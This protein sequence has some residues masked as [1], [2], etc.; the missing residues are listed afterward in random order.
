MKTGLIHKPGGTFLDGWGHRITFDE[1]RVYMKNGWIRS[2]F[3][4]SNG[5]S[6]KWNSP[7]DCYLKEEIN[8]DDPNGWKQLEDE[9]NVLLEKQKIKYPEQHKN[10]KS[11][12][13]KEINWRKKNWPSKMSIESIA[14]YTEYLLSICRKRALK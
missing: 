11:S 12:T 1:W 14:K 9:F 3:R 4:K 2:T 8:F 6:I 5:R 10:Q 13:I 7:F